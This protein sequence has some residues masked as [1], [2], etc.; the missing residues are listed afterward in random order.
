M[1]GLFT[2]IIGVTLA[3]AAVYYVLSWRKGWQS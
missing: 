2:I 1:T 3:A